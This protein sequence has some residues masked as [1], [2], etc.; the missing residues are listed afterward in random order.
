VNSSAPPPPLC[1]A[2]DATFWPWLRWPEFS[3]WP[4]PAGTTIIL[5]LA[6]MADWGLGHPLDAEEIVLLHVLRAA[7][8]QKPDGLRIL[9]APPLR[10]VLGPATGCAFAVEPP[11]AHALVAEVAAS[12]AASGFRRVVFYNSSPWNEELIGAAARD[13]RIAHRLQVF[14]ISLS[15]LGLDFHPVRS[16][17]R[18]KVQT[19]ITSLLDRAPEPPPAGAP[20]AGVRGWGDETVHPLT[21]PALPLEAARSE[22]AV[23]LAAAAQKLVSLL[24]EISARPPLAHDGVIPTARP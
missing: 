15:G 18:R 20:A 21:E 16:S 12:I 13:L 5:P 6:G 2:D 9:V 22:G 19:L 3:R 24:G 1:I 8:R 4:D 11:V 23:I 10:F 14:R 17:T 7:S